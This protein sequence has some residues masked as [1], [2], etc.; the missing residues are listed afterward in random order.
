MNLGKGT[1]IL[2]SL[3]LLFFC[4][5]MLGVLVELALTVD[6]PSP[7]S[8]F[9]L[10]VCIAFLAAF[11]VFVL[12][13][14]WR[15][16]KPK[17]WTERPL[18]T[19]ITIKPRQA[20][21]AEPAEDLTATDHR[22]ILYPELPEQLTPA[23]FSQLKHVDP[24]QLEEEVTVMAVSYIGYTGNHMSFSVDN[25]FSV[26][27]LNGTRYLHRTGEEVFSS[28]PP[29]P[30]YP[31]DDYYP[32]PPDFFR[33]N[34]EALR[35]DLIAVAKE[36]SGQIR[37]C[38]EHQKGARF[39]FP[40][41]LAE[42]AAQMQQSP[43]EPQEP[44][45]REKIVRTLENVFEGTRV[46][47]RTEARE[48]RGEKDNELLLR[49]KTILIDEDDG[50]LLL[51]TVRGR[52]DKLQ[53]TAFKEITYARMHALLEA[54]GI[55][56]LQERFRDLS[57]MNFRSFMKELPFPW[58]R[59]LCLAESVIGHGDFYARSRRTMPSKIPDGHDSFSMQLVDYGFQKAI[60]IDARYH[61]KRP[62]DYDD[63][64]WL[65]ENFFEDKTPAQ[66]ARDV[67]QILSD[68]YK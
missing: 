64:I 54:R 6:A 49:S 3:I 47:F 44:A 26:G 39:M 27:T 46:L 45:K 17:E 9:L 28:W 55:E 34:E 42:I 20:F 41:D 56:A 32:L 24:M 4:G 36:I 35:T 7:G 37:Y 65:P 15:K 5:T 30:P 14:L 18:K 31:L 12:I 23:Y 10:F 25:L 19:Q 53:V 68:S 66:A 40:D 43:A 63:V 33:K 16:P 2:I 67:E 59:S 13:V 8:R 1:K 21:P 60:E 58:R 22:T 48:E 57:L 29:D 38:C 51:V 52:P 50:T 11:V 62:I 61:D